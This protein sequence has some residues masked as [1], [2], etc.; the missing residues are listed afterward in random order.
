MTESHHPI[1][2]RCHTWDKVRP[3]L[4]SPSL[5]SP[6]CH[7]CNNVG[8][9]FDTPSLTPPHYP[10]HQPRPSRGWN[11]GLSLWRGVGQLVSIQKSPTEIF[12]TLVLVLVFAFVLVIVHVHVLIL[13][14]LLILAFVFLLILVHRLI[15]VLYGNGMISK[16]FC[17][18]FVFYFRSR[19]TRVTAWKIP[20]CLGL[21]S[22]E[23]F[24]DVSSFGHPWTFLVRVFCTLL[25]VYGTSRNVLI[26]SL[27]CF[28]P[29]VH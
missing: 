13:V 27:S 6:R 22:T 4:I 2:H 1:L 28:E 21:L 17:W 29:A 19:W 24:S 14:L 7:T 26:S 3:F 11:E 20:F 15:F 10:P 18:S 8:P 12:I 25:T 5:M 16:I 23:R 9:F